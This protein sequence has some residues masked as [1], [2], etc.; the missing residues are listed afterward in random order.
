MVLHE[1]RE[2]H[3]SWSQY[4]EEGH[5]GMERGRRAARPVQGTGELV[6]KLGRSGTGTPDEKAEFARFM[7]GQ[8][9]E[10]ANGGE[11]V[12]SVR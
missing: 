10:S 11:E 1:R 2:D 12:A 8:W 4:R 6:G 7:H 3:H 9:R 5:D